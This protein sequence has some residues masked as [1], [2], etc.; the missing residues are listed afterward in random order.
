MRLTAQTVQEFQALSE[1]AN[2]P[3]GTAP[4]RRSKG[5]SVF[6][7]STP[8]RATPNCGLFSIVVYSDQSSFLILL[9]SNIWSLLALI[10]V[11]PFDNPL[12]IHSRNLF[13]SGCVSNALCG[14]YL[15]AP[16]S[17]RLPVREIAWR[18]RACPILTARL[19]CV[20]SQ[21]EP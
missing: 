2:N 13:G 20:Q 7:L 15:G 5:I 3:T 1:S 11:R 14:N 4:P 10:Y 17:N 9:L 6:Y 21:E 18:C 16:C 8:T 12:M 19:V